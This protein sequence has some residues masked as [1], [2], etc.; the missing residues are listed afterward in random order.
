M[1]HFK[2]YVN[3]VSMKLLPENFIVRDNDLE[4]WLESQ[5]AGRTPGLCLSGSALGPEKLCLQPTPSDSNT[6]NTRATLWETRLYT[7]LQLNLA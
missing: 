7:V 2:W 1:A 4:S 5:G 3:H 6:D